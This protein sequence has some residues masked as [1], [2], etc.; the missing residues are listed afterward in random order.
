[1]CGGKSHIGFS[2]DRRLIYEHRDADFSYSASDGGG[3]G[4]SDS[5]DERAANPSCSSLQVDLLGL[6]NTEQTAEMHTVAVHVVDKGHTSRVLL[7]RGH[8]SNAVC[9]LP[10]WPCR[11]CL[12]LARR[13]VL[14]IHRPVSPPCFM[15]HLTKRTRHGEPLKQTTARQS[16]I[17]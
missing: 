12:A 10:T 17:R 16:Y 11:F 9:L 1:M 15:S 13:P 6:R 4:F 14:L 5:C 8:D 3:G 7:H 2:F